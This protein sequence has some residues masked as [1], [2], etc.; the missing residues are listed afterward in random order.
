ME[1][2]SIDIIIVN[3]NSTEIV[4]NC[5]KSIFTHSE[6]YDL[7]IIVFDN[8]SIDL[9]LRIKKCF[10]KIEL[11][12][13]DCN[14]GF[15][16]AINSA[17]KKAG[18][19]IVVLLNP[20][21][22]IYKGFF[23]Q[24]VNYLIKNK[25]VAIVGPKIIEPNG[26]IQ[27]SARKFPTP[28]TSLFGRKSPL[29]RIFPNN[30]ITKKE[31]VSFAY[32]G[33]EPI[34]VDW[35]SGACMI[36]RKEAIVDV[37]GFDEKFFLYWED[38]DLCKRLKDSGWDI[39]YYPSAK[40]L[41]HAGKSS[42]TRP[43]FSTYHFHK[44]CFLLFSKHSRWP[45][46]LLYPIAFLGL[47]LRC[48]LVIFI[49]S[50][51]IVC[52]KIKFKLNAHPKFF[53]EIFKIIFWKKQSQNKKIVNDTICPRKVKVLRIVS[54]LNIGG[55][56]IHCAIL[57]TGLNKERFISKLVKG[58]ISRFEG[59]MS[60][61][62]RNL[63]DGIINIP[64]LQREIDLWQ[65]IRA[66]G[67]IARTIFKEKPD[68]VHTHLAK[69]GALSR[70]AVFFYNLISKDKIKTVHTYHGHVL[71]GYFSALKSYFFILVERSLARI[72]D[73]IIA[74]STTQKS[75]L[76]NK[77]RIA[78]GYKIHTINLGFDLSHFLSPYPK[79]TVRNQIGLKKE[80]ALIGIIGRLAPI[81][82]HLLFLD[83]AKIIKNKETRKS[84]R[85][86]I[87]GDGELRIKLQNYANQLGLND[88]VYFYGWEKDIKKIYSE[89]NIL[90]LTSNNEGTPVSIIEAMA[91]SVP[92]VTTGVGGI[93]DLLGN[94]KDD[95]N[96][97]NGFSVCERGIVCPKGDA[98]AIANGIVYLLE[99]DNSER[100]RNAQKFVFENYTDK[101][102]IQ[103][104]EKLYEDL[105][106]NYR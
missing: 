96:V 48:I 92:V 13:N 101:R 32:K 33:T 28:L 69:A 85:Y 84:I 70:V 40:I 55:P 93:K 47:S 22:H 54:R 98:T 89:L 35:V 19:E 77:Y 78:K 56:S 72:T 17:L 25:N 64:E 71:E 88:D 37:N 68:I 31:F 46:I 60:Y 103:N 27:G 2:T 20:D 57:A 94:E 58:E 42:N 30:S 90:V 43:F 11:I 75:E 74:I 18:S 4:I 23:G 99:N 104:I 82:N 62:L 5:I 73:A 10:P 67:K 52:N 34:K 6:N 24:V 49:Q 26:E 59:D 95:F 9:P 91:A 7:N 81:K 106:S 12:C 51:N 87:V 97:Q 29:T 14:V 79:K 16:R 50:I 38:T 39:I 15:G 76:S 86:I 66:F 44:S 36:V 102:L 1:K 41:H 3:Y 65:D 100:I 21:T 61:I 45:V 8:N 105:L 53:S 80:E 63:N 83:A